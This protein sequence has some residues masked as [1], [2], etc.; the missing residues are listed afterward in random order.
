MDEKEKE[1]QEFTGRNKISC[2]E[3]IVYVTDLFSFNMH[4]ARVQVLLDYNM[5]G[6]LVNLR[7]RDDVRRA[8]RSFHG[9][10]II[11]NN[12]MVIINEEGIINGYIR[13]KV[14]KV[15]DSNSFHKEL[16]SELYRYVSLAVAETFISTLIPTQ[17]KN[18]E[19]ELS[20]KSKIDNKYE[21]TNQSIIKFGKDE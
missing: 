21:F 5:S 17:L 19:V 13:D 20:I 16:F 8:V 3:R 9:K 14:I 10:F 6:D 15:N 7:L 1:K 18:T 4:I 2:N 12:Q 11:D